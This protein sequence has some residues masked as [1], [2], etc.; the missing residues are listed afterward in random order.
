MFKPYKYDHIFRTI[1]SG[2]MIHDS[3]LN[4]PS[5]RIEWIT[6]VTYLGMIFLITVARFLV[7]GVGTG[8]TRNKTTTQLITND[9]CVDVDKSLKKHHHNAESTNVLIALLTHIGVGLAFVFSSFSL[10]PQ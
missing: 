7:D 1:K 9:V 5:D 3:G 2:F 6:R 8:S 10:G 4:C